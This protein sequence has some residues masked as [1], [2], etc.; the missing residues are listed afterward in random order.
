V[1][2]EANPTLDQVLQQVKQLMLES[3]TQQD[4]PFE[5]VVEA[6]KPP[7]SASYSPVFQ[8]MLYTNAGGAGGELQ[9]PGLSLDFLPSRKDNTQHDLS[10]HIDEGGASLSCSLSYST[11]LF[12]VATIE[13]LAGRFERLLRCFTEAPDTRIGAWE[14]DAALALP[15]VSAQVPGPGP[16]PLSYHQERLWF[17]DTFETGYLYD[18]NPIYHNIALL[19]EL[20]GEI[21]QAALQTALD[22]LLARHAILRCRV[23]SDGSSAWQQFDGPAGG[24]S[25]GRDPPPAEHE[26][27]Q[28]GA[29]QPG[30]SERSARDPG[31]GRAPFA[32]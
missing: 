8:T 11:A 14:L 18:A 6:L 3:S 20:N 10:L 7:R 24:A 27:R 26:R 30:K 9:L 2:L 13:R 15:E 17:V 21:N 31:H 25:P 28:P 12:D 19:L 22:G 29:C 1:R 5:L 16:L 32:G 23:S 4:T